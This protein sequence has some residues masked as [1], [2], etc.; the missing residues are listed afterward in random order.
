MNGEILKELQQVL[1]ETKSAPT[2]G[3]DEQ[4]AGYII[5][6]IKYFRE[7]GVP[8][9][10]LYKLET[11]IE[12][13]LTDYVVNNFKDFFKFLNYDISSIYYSLEVLKKNMQFE[14][15]ERLAMPL[16]DYLELHSELYSKGQFCF[17]HPVERV[18]YRLERLKKH[19]IFDKNMVSANGNYTAFFLSYAEILNYLAVQPESKRNNCSANYYLDCA[20][21]ISPCN[22]GVWMTRASVMKDD[23]DEYFRCMS[24]ALEYT[25]FIK[26]P[27]GLIEIYEYL[28]LHYAMKENFVLSSACCNACIY[29]GGNPVSAKY[30]LSKEEIDVDES[31]DWQ[32]VL[33]ENKIQIGFSGIVIEACQMIKDSQENNDELEYI[34]AVLKISKDINGRESVNTVIK[35]KSGFLKIIFSKKN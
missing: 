22:P 27:Y 34:D 29:F 17:Q 5:E 23:E 14:Q 25:Y 24:K 1:E 16:A 9:R 35:K 10:L 8:E 32:S 18:V 30:V 3:T 12:I 11:R 20:E 33:S 28:A 19:D 31:D 21:K 26:Q 2:S 7:R 4:N 6:K 15:A 13:H